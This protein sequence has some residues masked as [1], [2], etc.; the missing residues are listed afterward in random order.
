MGV[1]DRFKAKK[2][3][4][5]GNKTR[6]IVFFLVIALAFTIPFLGLQSELKKYK[7]ET[8]IVVLKENIGNVLIEES[9]LKQVRWVNRNVTGDMIKW[10]DREKILNKYP[11][12]QLPP[13]VP[14]YEDMFTD[15]QIVRYEYLYE[16]GPDEELFTFN[17]DVN[18]AGGEITTVN[19]RLRIRGS[20]KMTEEEI[21]RL[22]PMIEESHGE[23]IRGEVRDADGNIIEEEF[24]EDDEIFGDTRVRTIFS[25]VRVTDLL[26]SKGR[27]IYE[28]KRQVERMPLVEREKYIATD[29][30][31]QDVTPTA[32][33]LVVKSDEISRFLSFDANNNVKY[34]ITLLSRDPELL[35][36]EIKIGESLIEGVA[37]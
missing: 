33:M 16:L 24:R 18:Q 22:R 3:M 14:L 27:S 25:M 11:K 35:D 1:L 26:N 8:A 5:G 15:E 36:E 4:S 23:L 12:Y 20:Y 6:N 2:R 19:E 29:E 31:K 13:N 17:F 30:Y 9:H 34:T 7:K 32:M 21:E 37:R 10:A 28:I